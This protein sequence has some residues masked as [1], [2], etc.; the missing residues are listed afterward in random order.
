MKQWC[1]KKVLEPKSYNYIPELIKKVFEK[2]LVHLL[3]K[4]LVFQVKTQGKL[5][6]TSQQFHH[7]LC[8]HL[9]K[10]INPGLSNGGIQKFTY[11]VDGVH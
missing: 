11:W 5:H 1:P 8:S 4:E 10:L 2:H 7:L 9:W 3:V 6:Q